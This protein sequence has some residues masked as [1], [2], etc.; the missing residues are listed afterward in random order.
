MAVAV[1]TTLGFSVKKLQVASPK[2]E[3][4]WALVS[5]KLPSPGSKSY[6]CCALYSPPNSKLKRKLLQHIEYNIARLSSSYP[7]SGV[8]IGGDI[9]DLKLNELCEVYPNM[10]CVVADPTHNNKV[11][12]VIVTTAYNE[13]DRARIY[14]PI[15]PD[16]VG[17]GVES[18][19]QVAVATAIADP[20]NRKSLARTITRSRFNLSAA[21]LL[22][23]SM[24]LATFPLGQSVRCTKCDS[25]D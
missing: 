9:N 14:P 7:G 12:D 6:I 10:K 4:C 23:L 24:F 8:I 15:G 5:P 25:D 16:V 13:Y 11:L 20:T 19:H 18:D 17:N 21:N 1:D 22:R 2:L 3:T